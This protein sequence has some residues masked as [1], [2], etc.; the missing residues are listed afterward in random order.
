M[1]LRYMVIASMQ[2]FKLDEAAN[3]LKNLKEA[4][5]TRMFQDE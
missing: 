5:V 4:I 3:H 2:A 1:M